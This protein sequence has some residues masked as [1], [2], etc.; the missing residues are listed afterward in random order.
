MVC[1][2]LRSGCTHYLSSRLSQS[3]WNLRNEPRLS[4]A[5]NEQRKLR[6]YTRMS[7]DSKYINRPVATQQ[8]TEGLERARES[9]LSWGSREL[10][11]TS[12]TLYHLKQLIPLVNIE[13]SFFKHLVL[14]LIKSVSY[15]YSCAVY[16]T[17]LI[18]TVCLLKWNHSFSFRVYIETTP[19]LWATF[20][21]FISSFG[22]FFRRLLE[23][24]RY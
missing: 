7:C 3:A 5:L 4:R 9:L 18:F 2:R 22:H 11:A 16:H 12:N 10:R 20:L 24:D 13:D 6:C 15:D 23:I 21:V 19:T 14:Q 17:M 1:P 8:N